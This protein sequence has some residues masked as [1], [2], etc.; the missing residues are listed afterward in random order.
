MRFDSQ[1]KQFNV[2]DKVSAGTAAGTV[3]RITCCWVCAICLRVGSVCES[4]MH[5]LLNVGVACNSHT[6]VS[7]FARMAVIEVAKTAHKADSN[8]ISYSNPSALA[9]QYNGIYKMILDA[10]VSVHHA[11]SPHHLHI[12]GSDTAHAHSSNILHCYVLGL[13]VRHSMHTLCCMFPHCTCCSCGRKLLVESRPAVNRL[14][15][16]L[17]SW[18]NTC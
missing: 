17:H 18:S 8:P 6:C 3:W 1:A 7:C 13:S 16:A 4:G 2:Q 14:M 11:G 9:L 10:D 15:K 12:I 5:S